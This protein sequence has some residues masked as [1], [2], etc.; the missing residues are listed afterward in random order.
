MEGLHKEQ[1]EPTK[2]SNSDNESDSGSD[3]DYD[4]LTGIDYARGEGVLESSSSS[5]YDDDDELT[6][7]NYAREA[8]APQSSADEEDIELVPLGKGKVR[9]Q[10][11]SI[12]HLWCIIW[13]LKKN[14]HQQLV[15]YQYEQL[16]QSSY[17]YLE[18][19]YNHSG[20]V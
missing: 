2:D 14:S 1:E 11:V 12:I 17:M 5:D 16:F 8:E 3:S 6:G 13:W 15:Q 9:W 20:I 4:Q 7:V 10:A 19:I 18:T